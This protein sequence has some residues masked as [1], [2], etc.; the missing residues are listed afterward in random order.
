MTTMKLHTSMPSQLI[1]QLCE[2]FAR[3]NIEA[4]LWYLGSD[5]FSDRRVIVVKVRELCFAAGNISDQRLGSFSCL[6]AHEIMT[7]G[8]VK[9]GKVVFQ[10]N[11][12]DE[13]NAAPQS[14][15]RELFPPGVGKRFRSPN[16]RP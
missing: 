11:G 8:R 7:R 13:Y 2:I 10:D 16:F 9:E 3:E 6:K 5:N 1:L 14:E 12:S 4:V 15:N